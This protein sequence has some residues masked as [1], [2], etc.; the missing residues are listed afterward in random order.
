MPPDA[1]IGRG[2]AI[3]NCGWDPLYVVPAQGWAASRAAAFDWSPSV[4]R[5]RFGG[6]ATRLPDDAP[7][8]GAQICVWEQRPDAIVP[9][10]SRILPELTER[11][12]NGGGEGA[13]A[14]F[15]ASPL[16]SMLGDV[17]RPVRFAART[18]DRGGLVA[19][20][21]VFR[22][23]LALEMSSEASG[24]VRFEVGESPR[25][26]TTGSAA[27]DGEPL[28]LADSAYV[29]ARLFTH[30]GEA[31]GGTT[32]TR[33][34]RAAPIWRAEVFDDSADLADDDDRAA[35]RYGSGLL[36]RPDAARIGEINR[37]LFARVN[38]TAHVDTRVLAWTEIDRPRDID[39]WRPRVWGRH[40][41]HARGTI[42]IPESGEWTIACRSNDGRT[43]IRM[44][45]TVVASSERGRRTT[46]TGTLEAG[47]YAIEFEHV[48]TGVHDELQV[49][50]DGPG[51]R[52]KVPLTDLV[53]DLDDER[54]REDTLTLTGFGD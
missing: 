26:V 44:G 35:R 36:V 39:P 33:F 2:H 30:G 28:K 50:L 5:Q 8:K 19:D 20:G 21:T 25:P 10:V 41:V 34:V 38:P 1:L 49:W 47:T 16:R 3:V 13:H 23:E 42:A 15:D 11:M 51:G 27:Y 31:I 40:R 12:W 45:G 17:L 4:V 14:E 6:R 54:T 22:G 48:V 52:E 29:S 9:A 7:V 46:R 32:V 53:L 18:T 24:V 43:T 37:E